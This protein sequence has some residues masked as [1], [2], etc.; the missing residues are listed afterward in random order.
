MAL[1]EDSARRCVPRRLT[2]IALVAIG[3]MPSAAQDAHTSVCRVVSGALAFV[4]QADVC[5][6]GSLSGDLKGRF[7]T[8]VTS[9]YPAGSG[10]IYTGWTKIELDEQ[11]GAVETVNYAMTPFDDKGGPDLAHPTEILTLTEA[12]GKW[13]EY[14]GTIVL[15]GGHASGQP[16][17]YIGRLCRQG[18]ADRVLQPQRGRQP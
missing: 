4:C 12:T 2:T 11:L 5:T 8:R 14:S 17:G 1:I 10:W 7:T 18:V 13:E 15:S 9:I 16:V 6:S 3:A